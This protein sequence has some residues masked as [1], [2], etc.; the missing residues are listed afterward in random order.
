MSLMLHTQL[1]RGAINIA[2]WPSWN[3]EEVFKLANVSAEPTINEISVSDPT[4]IGLPVLDTVTTTSEIVISGDAVNF[5]PA[6]A[7][8]VMYGTVE[9]V[10]SGTVSAEPHRAYIDRT[11]RLANMP[12]A[13]TSVKS[14]DDQATYTRNIDFAVTPAG[15]RILP[16]GPLADAIAAALPADGET[17]KSVPITVTYSY[18]TVDVIKPFT[19]GQKWWRVMAGQQN[20]AGN[21]E[22]RR[23]QCFYCRILLNGGIPLNQGAE[24]GTV[25]VQI[26][27]LPDPNI[28][29]PGEASMWQWEVEVKES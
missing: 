19:T 1:F 25:P 26:K 27:V 16:G 11:I 13:V 7:A 9:R 3:F 15:I 4:R 12:L 24:F 21:Q 8:I 22:R 5:S 10:P 23:I 6:A 20:E 28:Y 14:A 29:D 17:L 2:A 18:P